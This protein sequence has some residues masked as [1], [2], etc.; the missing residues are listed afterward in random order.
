MKLSCLTKI[1]FW[2]WGL[3]VPLALLAQPTAQDRTILTNL[4]AWSVQEK[5]LDDYGVKTQRCVAGALEFNA[6][7]HILAAG[8]ADQES[9]R[10]GLLGSTVTSPAVTQLRQR[11]LAIWQATQSVGKMSYLQLATCL[12]AVPVAVEEVVV[13][14]FDLGLITA[15]AEVEKGRGSSQNWTV[16]SLSQV[17]RNVVP[18]SFLQRAV[19]T[20]FAYNAQSTQFKAHRETFSECLRSAL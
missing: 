7:A 1:L 13:N 15:L 3:F 9:M 20:V 2:N 8:K 18:L 10:A 6:N 11:Q 19:A 17:T 14:C 16:E 12:E 5:G 4:A